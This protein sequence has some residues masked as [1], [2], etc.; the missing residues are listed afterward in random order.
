MSVGRSTRLWPD[1]TNVP[2]YTRRATWDDLKT[3]AQLLNEVVGEPNIFPQRES[4]PAMQ[5]RTDFSPDAV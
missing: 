4:A 2:E 3:L 5:F 1:T